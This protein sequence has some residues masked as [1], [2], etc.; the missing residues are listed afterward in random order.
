MH[1]CQQNWSH[2]QYL[3][4]QSRDPITKLYN[5]D[6]LT[7]LSICWSSFRYCSLARYQLFFLS[8]LHF[9][10]KAI[11]GALDIISSEI[12]KCCKS[13]NLYC[14]SCYMLLAQVFF[15]LI[16][17][18]CFTYTSFVYMPPHTFFILTVPLNARSLRTLICD[19]RAVSNVYAIIS[20]LYSVT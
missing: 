14:S 20:S 9:A 7:I 3:H 12:F 16:L 4:D 2:L 6:V 8:L 5:F 1:S 11:L 10:S 19:S 17:N 18:Q 15:G 13:G